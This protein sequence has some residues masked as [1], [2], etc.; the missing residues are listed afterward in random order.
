M[1]RRMCE[2]KEELELNREVIAMHKD[3]TR[4]NF[5]RSFNSYGVCITFGLIFVVLGFYNR[6]AV[7][8]EEGL[9]P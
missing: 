1:T 2:P 9:N 5:R 7:I 3:A 8:L 6:K 4:G